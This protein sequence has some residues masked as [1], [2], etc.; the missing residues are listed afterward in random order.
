MATNFAETHS[1]DL[2]ARRSS[3]DIEHKFFIAAAIFFP[4]ITILGFVPNY[5]FPLPYKPP[6][7]TPIVAVHSVAMSLWIVL[8][9]LQAALISAK[10]VRLHM[11]LGLASIGLAVVMTVSGLLVGY[12][13]AAGGRAFPGFTP[14]EFLAI[15]AGD[16]IT[17]VPLFAA[18]IYYRKIP[19]NHKRLMLVVM[20]NFLAP[21]IGRLPLPFIPD[22]GAI[23]FFGPPAVIGLTVLAADTYIFGKL[24][25]AFAIGLAFMIAS[26]P[27]RVAIC[28]TEAWT[29]FVRSI[30]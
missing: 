18:A 22:L 9:S 26:G 20:L 11:T 28:R 1:F 16:M 24:N 15:P 7:I 4:L 8:F 2:A 30:I 29:D 17:F 12:Y 25:R 21:S 27:I 10:K 19:A 5:I 13:A 14:E 3:A 23:W 6:P